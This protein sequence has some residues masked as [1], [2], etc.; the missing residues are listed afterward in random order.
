MKKNDWLL[1]AALSLGTAALGDPITVCR[2]QDP[3]L[4]YG[5]RITDQGT[6]TATVAETFQDEPLLGGP[7]S[8]SRS[9]GPEKDEARYRGKDFQLAVY[10]DWTTDEFSAEFSG[11]LGGQWLNHAGF[12]CRFFDPTAVPPPPRGN[13]H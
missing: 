13:Q 2:T 10:I 12:T 4:G 1:W 6:A 5:L 9:D 7:L 11:I 3:R 8:V